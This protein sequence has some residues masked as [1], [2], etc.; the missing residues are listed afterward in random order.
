VIDD[1]AIDRIVRRLARPQPSGELVVE[2]ASLLA[3]G[4][5]CSDI[6]AWILRNGGEAETSD[7]S[8]DGDA[9]GG[10]FG[11]RRS[12]YARVGSGHPAR[13]FI[14]AGALPATQAPVAEEL[15]GPH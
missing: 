5:H 10:I 9:G 7:D 14:P 13:Y 11:A 12:A 6:E 15:A 2:R 3:E 8:P 4:P 1:A